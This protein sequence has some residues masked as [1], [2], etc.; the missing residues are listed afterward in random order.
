MA[1]E[2]NLTG[3]EDFRKNPQNI[4]RNGRPRKS[5]AL[6]NAELKEKGV[7]PLTKSQLIE[8]YSLIFNATED[9]LKELAKAENT[10]CAMKIIIEELKGKAS[11]A[12]AFN[13]YRDYL[14]GKAAQNVGLTT[15]K[16]I[17]VEYV[18]VSKQFPNG[19]LDDEE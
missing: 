8:A 1:N 13:D 6:I 10:P 7:E 11:R 5:F 15:N 17:V 18:N 12:R 19:L 9:D 4:N 3:A 16:K 2:E 14:F